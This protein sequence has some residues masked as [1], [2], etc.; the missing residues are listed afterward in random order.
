MRRRLG[1]VRL[2]EL[3]EYLGQQNGRLMDILHE[4]AGIVTENV[5]CRHGPDGSPASV[6]EWDYVGEVRD[7]EAIS[8][9]PDG[10]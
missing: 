1:I 8:N 5:M 9:G 3:R 10:I 4:M 7:H 2:Y 6:S